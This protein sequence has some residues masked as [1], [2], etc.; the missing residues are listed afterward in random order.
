LKAEQSEHSHNQSVS[1]LINDNQL[2][3]KWY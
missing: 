1:Q 2:L 3:L